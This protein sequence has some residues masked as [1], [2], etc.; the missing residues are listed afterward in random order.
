MFSPIGNGY[1]SY[2]HISLPS[3]QAYSLYI[4]HCFCHIHRPRTCHTC[5]YMPPHSSPL[6]NLGY[7]VHFLDR[8]LFQ[9]IFHCNN[10]Y[11]IC[12]TFLLYILQCRHHPVDCKIPDMYCTGCHIF[13]H[14]IHVDTHHKLHFHCI[15]S[16]DT[17]AG[18]LHS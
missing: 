4:F 8:I 5:D 3:N 9:N 13:F 15:R 14:K 17:A 7:K 16:L 10:S 1:Y 2:H 11:N 12:Q 18:I 6:N